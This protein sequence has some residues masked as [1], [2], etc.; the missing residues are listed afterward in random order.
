MHF[1]IKETDIKKEISDLD[2]NEFGEDSDMEEEEIQSENETEPENNNI[3]ISNICNTTELIPRKT[4][5]KYFRTFEK[6]VQKDKG[7]FVTIGL[8]RI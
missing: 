2:L 1:V 5:L 8:V 4:L 6:V 3:D 7:D